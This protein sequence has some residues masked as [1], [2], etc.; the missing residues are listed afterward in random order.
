METVKLIKSEKE[1]QMDGILHCGFTGGIAISFLLCSGKN[2]W[3]AIKEI[4]TVKPLQSLC[5]TY[6]TY[7][8]SAPSLSLNNFLTA[9]TAVPLLQ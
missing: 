4:Q 7:H 1:L 9:E 2:N 8:H 5:I 3:R 6:H